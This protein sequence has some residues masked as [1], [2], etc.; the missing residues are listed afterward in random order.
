MDMEDRRR[1]SQEMAY[2][3]LQH[4]RFRHP[5]T[6]EW[7]QV[8]RLDVAQAEQAFRY[9][10]LQWNVQWVACDQCQEASHTVQHAPPH[11]PEMPEHH[12]TA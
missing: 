2:G 11:L 4:Y 10:G 7:M 1:F 6:R 9:C 5:D 3:C 12:S 8:T